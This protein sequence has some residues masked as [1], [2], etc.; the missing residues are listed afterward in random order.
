MLGQR[1]SHALAT[2][3]LP[4]R[5]SWSLEEGHDSASDCA[6]QQLDMLWIPDGSSDAYEIPHRAR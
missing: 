4:S 5:G 2:P 3:T 1:S 6:P